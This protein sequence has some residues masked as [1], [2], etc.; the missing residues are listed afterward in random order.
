MLSSVT[1]ASMTSLRS[2]NPYVG[3]ALD[4][5]VAASHGSTWMPRLDGAA[6][7]TSAADGHPAIGCSAFAFQ[8]GRLCI[9]NVLCLLTRVE[10]LVLTAHPLIVTYTQGDHCPAATAA[11]SC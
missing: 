5:H 2:V 3:S 9:A 4:A 11:C 8:A 10:L 1:S 7:L 6:L